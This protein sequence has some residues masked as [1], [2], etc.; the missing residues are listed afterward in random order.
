MGTREV[1]RDETLDGTQTGLLRVTF[2]AFGNRHGRAP[3]ANLRSHSI[4]SNPVGL[5]L[6][7][8]HMLDRAP[9]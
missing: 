5:H 7:S 8:A 9:L 4:A 3:L 2:H 1:E 6:S